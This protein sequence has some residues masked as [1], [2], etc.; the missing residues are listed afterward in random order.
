MKKNKLVNIFTFVILLLPIINVYSSPINLMPFGDFILIIVILLF[1]LNPRKKY[2]GNDGHTYKP[3]IKYLIFIIIHFS[4]YAFFKGENYIYASI[5]NTFHYVFYLLILIVLI[6]KFFN[7]IIGYRLFKNIS[8]FSTVYIII[9]EILLKLTGVYLTGHIPGIKLLNPEIMKFNETA[10]YITSFAV[11]PRSIFPEPAHYAQYVLVFLALNLSEKKDGRKEYLIPLFLSF[12]I[13]ISKSSTGIILCLLL[14]MYHL[15]VNIKKAKLLPTIT[16]IFSIPLVISF[17]INS[18]DFNI[19]LDRFMSNSEFGTSTINRFGSYTI[20]LNS[21]NSNSLIQMIF[22]NGMIDEMQVY[23]PGFVRLFYYFG[24]IGVCLMLVI[25]I[26]LFRGTNA[27]NRGLWIL[28][29]VMN[30]GGD[31][32]FG[33]NLLLFVPFLLVNYTFLKGIPK[34]E[35]KRYCANIQL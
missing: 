2:L 26:Q 5:I 27:A 8:V 33:A 29:L 3:F 19:F 20:M 35:N 30:I 21:L 1:F 25:Y 17:L 28:M 32:I 12:G 9:Q 34:N 11:R 4:I 18:S 6:K 7:P 23:M 15:I 10:S 31:S 22:G 16:Y 14:W 24:I 13:L